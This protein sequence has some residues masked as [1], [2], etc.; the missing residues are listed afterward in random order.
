MYWIH[1]KR[2]QSIYFIQFHP[3]KSKDQRTLR[4]DLEVDLKCSICSL[5]IN[6][7]VNPA[8]IH[9]QDNQIT[10]IYINIYERPTYERRERNLTSLQEEDRTF[11]KKNRNHIPLIRPTLI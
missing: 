8:D 5:I 2:Y 7:E 4:V 3:R 1:P 6:K 11:E 9:T 10:G